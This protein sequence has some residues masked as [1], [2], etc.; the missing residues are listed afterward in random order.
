M[1]V[2]QLSFDF[3]VFEEQNTVGD[4]LDTGI[5]GDHQRGGAQFLIDPIQGFQNDDPGLRIQRAGWVVTKQDLRFFGDGSSY[6]D[7]LLFAT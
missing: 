1:L 3:A 4:L 5:V 2:D 7:P 6:G